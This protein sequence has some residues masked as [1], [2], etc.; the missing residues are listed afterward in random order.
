MKYTRPLYG[1]VSGSHPASVCTC[2]CDVKR[3]QVF[4][5]ALNHASSPVLP[6]FTA[7]FISSDNNLCT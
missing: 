6:A 7:V 1:S 5:K 4:H 3:A 2:V